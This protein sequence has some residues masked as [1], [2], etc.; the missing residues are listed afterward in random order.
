MNRFIGSTLT[1]QGAASAVAVPKPATVEESE[2]SFL[3]DP[4]VHL[5]LSVALSPQ[6]RIG[7][8]FE[9]SFLLDQNLWGAADVGFDYR[10]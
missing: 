1:G 5:Q 9:T 3:F 2:E 6:L 7:G 8:R 10:F 4:E